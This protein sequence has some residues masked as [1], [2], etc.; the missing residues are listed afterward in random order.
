MK[1][2]VDVNA[3]R[4]L[5]Q[6]LSFIGYDLVYVSDRNPNMKDEDILRWAVEEQRIIVTTDN[7][8]EQ[9]IWQQ[10][11]P[12]CGV[13]RIENVPREERRILLENALKEHCQDLEAGFI[14]IALRN[15]FRIRR[16]LR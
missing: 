10:S 15:K 2:L 12:H 7:D 14:V 3:S 13:L 6:F 1:F 8:F 9:M 11:K 5:G 16:P 4:N